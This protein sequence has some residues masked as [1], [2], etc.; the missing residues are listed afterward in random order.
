S[1]CEHR[2]A[3]IPSCSRW[4]SAKQIVLGWRLRATDFSAAVLVEGLGVDV[5]G[6]S[7]TLRI[8]YRT[9]H[10]I[11]SR[12]DRLLGPQMSDVDGNIEERKGTVS[13]FNGPVPTIV[14][15]PD[16]DQERESVGKW[17]RA[18]IEEGVAPQEV[19]IFVRS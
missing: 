6:R 10:Q 14:T 15:L 7:M 11:R 12:A 13:L 1:G 2:P 8:N 3:S 9:S 19:A 4:K 5:R 16:R 17:L 18:R